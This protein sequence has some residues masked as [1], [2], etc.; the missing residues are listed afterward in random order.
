MAW[1]PDGRRLAA[2]DPPGTATVWHAGTGERL[3]TLGTPQEQLRRRVVGW[4]PDGKRLATGSQDGTVTV[5][6]AATG[7]P[8]LTLARHKA[9][10][11][12]LAWSPDGRRLASASEGLERKVIVWEVRTGKEDRAL[13]L[14]RTM[15]LLSED[16]LAWSGDG[17][18]LAV[19][20]NMTVQVWDT[21][22]WTVALRLERAEARTAA[23]SLD[24]KYLATGGGANKVWDAQTGREVFTV[25]QQFGAGVA[26][27]PDSRYLASLTRSPEDVKVVD[28]GAVKEVRVI[29]T[30]KLSVQVANSVRWTAD[31]KYLALQGMGTAC[32]VDAATGMEVRALQYPCG[33]LS[34]PGVWAADGSRFASLEEGA[35]QLWAVDTGRQLLAL[36]P[37]PA[38][39]LLT[40]LAWGPGGKQVASGS[41]DGTV[42][43]WDA[44]TGEPVRVLHGLAEEVEARLRKYY[45]FRMLS[46]FEGDV[47]AVAVAWSPD[48]KHLAAANAAGLVKVWRADSGN[49]VRG[50]STTGGAT[51]EPP[52]AAGGTLVPLAW[53]LDGTRLAA[54]AAGA[55]DIWDVDTGQKRKTLRG[56]PQ[57][58]VAL[59][60]SRDVRR[61]A[62]AD[63]GQSIR[64]WDAATG[65]AVLTLNEPRAPQDNPSAFISGLAWSPDGRR[66][67]AARNGVVRLWDMTTGQDLLVLR[68]PSTAVRLSGAQVAWSPD[69]WKLAATAS[70]LGSNQPIL[71]WEVT[72]TASPGPTPQGQGE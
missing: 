20:G 17:S 36:G 16:A 37:S 19:A 9:E 26:W 7:R 11:K 35:A 2:L 6:D 15:P 42:T 70:A 4:S 68:P 40:A 55:V 27:S 46:S 30:R 65:K 10:V 71:V 56:T 67:A 49:E 58:V 41:Q 43:V 64:V 31:G 45:K 23:W 63:A 54:A 21:R 59:S 53:S 1:S 12:A 57:R 60:W 13:D 51:Q 47:P 52:P 8:V 3:L 69:G 22:N 62:V 61:L 44:T 34:R 48:G 32:L 28:V 50:W 72:P 38:G 25:A 5:W 39:G 66:L 29:P 24:G 33:P 14:D 18:R